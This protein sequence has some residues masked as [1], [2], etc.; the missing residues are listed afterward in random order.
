MWW[1][2]SARGV[3][4]L[5]RGTKRWWNALFITSVSLLFRDSILL[6]KC[7]ALTRD[8]DMMCTIST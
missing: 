6:N 3:E 8:G 4:R 5:N 2:V 7:P 1:V